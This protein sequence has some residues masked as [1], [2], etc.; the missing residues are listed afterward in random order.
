MVQPIKRVAITQR[1]VED[2][3]RCERRDVL[4]QAWTSLLADC[5]LE[6]HP[7]PN[8]IGNADAYLRA[9]GIEAIVLS[10]GGNISSA[11][12]T[13]SGATPNVLPEMND[14]ATERDSL[15]RQLLIASIEHGWP[16]IGVCRGM[17]FISLFYGGRLEQVKDHAGTRHAVER[18]E[19]G[20][21]CDD[22]VNSFHN[23]GIPL[24]G[25]GDGLNVLATAAG[26][27]EAFV[28][29]SFPHL[30]IMWHPERNKPWSERDVA[31]FRDFLVTGKRPWSK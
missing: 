14:L 21:P 30:G 5:G 31:L 10:G 29:R 6:I 16:V 12:T 24:D 27:V 2:H 13:H 17:Q 25:L 7:I 15:E 1:V 3:G 28:H 22:R 8:R 20:F 19:A 4:D 18:R 9:C 26:H 11:W 23:Y